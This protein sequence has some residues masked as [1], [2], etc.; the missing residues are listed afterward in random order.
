[1]KDRKA[2]L[3]DMLNFSIPI[4]EIKKNISKI[5]WD[6]NGEPVIIYRSHLINILNR[7]LLGELS[8]N[9]VEDW[10]NLVE[11]REDLE[12]DEKYFDD[13]SQ[14]IHHLANPF[15]EGE[16][17]YNFCKETIGFLKRE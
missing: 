1:M 3:L 12:F 15:L 14:I 13:L 4:D 17:D 9:D 2:I 7:F 10:A 5:S 8:K 11:C 6:Y 16:L